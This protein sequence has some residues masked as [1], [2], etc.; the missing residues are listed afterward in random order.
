MSIEYKTSE[1]QRRASIRWNKEHPEAKRRNDNN[2][3][4]A[5][6]E[7]NR[8]NQARYQKKLRDRKAL[9]KALPVGVC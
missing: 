6:P 2:W 5:H 7:V 3:V 1:V 4:K 9:F 8:A